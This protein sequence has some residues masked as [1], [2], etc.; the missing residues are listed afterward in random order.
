MCHFSQHLQIEGVFYMP[1]CT[2]TRL[3]L[4]VFI[5]RLC[6]LKPKLNIFVC[7][8]V[9]FSHELCRKCCV[10]DICFVF[11]YK[12]EEQQFSAIFCCSNVLF[13]ILLSFLFYS[14]FF[15]MSIEYLKKHFEKLQILIF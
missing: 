9:S 15:C 5:F 14:L 3:F 1:V 11:W 4:L 6:V 13:Y 7:V 8:T 2:K 10:V 12:K